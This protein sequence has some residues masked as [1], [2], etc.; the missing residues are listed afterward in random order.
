MNDYEAV[1]RALKAVDIADLFTRLGA[2]ADGVEHS[3]EPEL[4]WELVAKL[5]GHPVASP[6]TRQLVVSILRRRE[7][8]AGSDPFAGLPGTDR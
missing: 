5:T 4:T 6:T 8:R 1:N 7:Q 3:T 2:T